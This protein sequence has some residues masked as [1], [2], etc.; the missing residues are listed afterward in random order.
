[1]SVN[2]GSSPISYGRS[3][4]TQ[5]NP[6]TVNGFPYTLAT[7]I[8]SY[9]EISVNGSTGGTHEGHI[10]AKVQATVKRV[11]PAIEVNPKAL[12]FGTV[13]VRRAKTLR[14]HIKNTGNAVLTG[15][16]GS[17]SPPFSITDHL[18]QFPNGTFTI[19]PGQSVAVRLRFS[20]SSG[21]AFGFNDFARFQQQLVVQSNDADYPTVNVALSGVAE[22]AKPEFLCSARRPDSDHPGPYLP[23][24]PAR[25]GLFVYKY[26]KSTSGDVNDL[27]D[28]E[29]RALISANRGITQP[30]WSMPSTSYNNPDD[31]WN[32]GGTSVPWW[33]GTRPGSLPYFDCAPDC[34][35]LRDLYWWFHDY[36]FIDRI[37][38]Y[39]RRHYPDPSDYMVS[40]VH[41]WRVYVP[42]G[43]E[44]MS[45][46]PWRDLPNGAQHIYRKLSWETRE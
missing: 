5:G 13:T 8:N 18:S 36:P 32:P 26:I 29:F 20:P 25:G 44:E 34:L 43:W 35:Y 41:Q 42:N 23:S 19:Q 16:I 12:L 37:V 30:P 22:R 31:H 21:I 45:D 6:I 17:V 14:F 24:H 40:Q 1:M 7:S 4:A 11:A 27:R 33:D 15:Q 3:G 9:G 28:I 10:T 2:N 39:M 38:D 46:N